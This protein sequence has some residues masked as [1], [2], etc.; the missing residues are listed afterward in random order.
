MDPDVRPKAFMLL[1]HPF[2]KKAQGSSDNGKSLQKAKIN[3][4]LGD[5]MNYKTAFR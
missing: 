5:I 3:I 1:E 4:N 2:F